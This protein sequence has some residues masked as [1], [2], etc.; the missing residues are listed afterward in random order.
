MDELTK[1]ENL[2][3]SPQSEDAYRSIRGYVIEAQG[4]VYA[5]VNAAMVTAYWKI[6]KSIFEA[7]GENDRAAY[8][9]Q[10]LQYI[11]ERLTEEFGKGFNLRN[12][13]YMR[14]F[15]LAFPNVNALRSELS[16]THYRSLMKVSDAKARTFYLEECAKAGWS[17]RQLE[18]QINTMFYQRML[19]SRN[20]ESVAAEIQTTEPKPE[21]ERIIKDPYVLEFLD[22]PAN[23][24]FYESK[25]LFNI[26]PRPPWRHIFRPDCVKNPC[27]PSGLLRLFAL[28]DKKPISPIR[29]R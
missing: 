19:A 26:S 8:G 23:E 6:G 4:Q 25:S 1:R 2:P 27:N 15:Y 7:C 28:Q 9:K 24:H 20:K 5:A 12:L 10:V 11:S 21:Y 29:T 13:R 14:Q 16:W 22:L 18:R 17:S 3:D